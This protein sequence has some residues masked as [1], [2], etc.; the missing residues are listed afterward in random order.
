V[1]VRLEKPLEDNLARKRNLM[2]A[3]TQEFT[4]LLEYGVGDVSAAGMFYLAEIYA[5]FSKALTASERPEG[6][7]PLEL[8]QYELA[9]E[10]Q[11]Y[12]FEEKAI[13]IH[14]KNLKLIA[15]GIYNQWVD[16]SLQKLA[17]FVP[18]RYA[19]P[20]ATGEV[21][22]SPES[23]MFAIHPQ[24]PAGTPLPETQ[25]AVAATVS[26]EPVPAA[27]PAPTAEP[28]PGEEPGAVEEQAQAPESTA[29]VPPAAIKRTPAAADPVDE[30]EVA[31]DPALGQK[32]GLD[33]GPATVE[34]TLPVA[35]PAGAATGETS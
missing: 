15:Q 21:V 22:A 23:F 29:P 27:G 16:Q 26:A 14:E 17:V 3:A 4:R 11:A 33:E 13:D 6:L 24:G 2:K 28:V 31:P 18:A 19:K 5:H 30:P 1:E 7:S 34:G 25:A 12:P 35:G 8:E 9:I 32:E 20:E 10:E